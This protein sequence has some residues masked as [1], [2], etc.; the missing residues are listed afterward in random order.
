[1]DLKSKI[2]HDIQKEYNI[3]I[4]NGQ[5]PEEAYNFDHIEFAKKYGYNE[6]IL[7]EVLEELNS[8]GSI[9]MDIIG[10]FQFKVD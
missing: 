10:N 7:I 2:L 9:K 4:S 3:R 5:E 1:M 8:D 6:D